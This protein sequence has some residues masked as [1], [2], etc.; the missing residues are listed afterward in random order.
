MPD[1][2]YT[3][4]TVVSGSAGGFVD[5]ETDV[6]GVLNVI[7]IA[8]YNSQSLNV[9]NRE[10]VMFQADSQGNLRVDES[11]APQAEDNTNGVF[12]TAYKPVVG[13]TY[14][15]LMTGTLNTISGGL[16][17]SSAGNLLSAYVC[18]DTPAKIYLQ[19]FNLGA[20]PVNGTVPRYFF[21]VPATTITGP[22]TLSVGMD[23]FTQAGDYFSTGISWAV[24][25]LSGSCLQL[26]TTSSVAI[27][28]Q[29]RYI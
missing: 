1:F 17:K 19:L 23:L 26:A 6:T 18:N 13:N 14:A 28:T 21:P 15:P 5:A 29:F 25:S 20:A 7:P 2:S 12:A 22:G 27:A 3:P 11:F 4:P 16:I 24:S 8:Q 10:F 9:N